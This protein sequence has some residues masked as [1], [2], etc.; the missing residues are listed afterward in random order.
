MMNK[1]GIV[2]ASV[3]AFFAILFIAQ[4]I[5]IGYAILN[6]KKSKN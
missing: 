5:L 4:I 3:I 6:T 1:E 2:F